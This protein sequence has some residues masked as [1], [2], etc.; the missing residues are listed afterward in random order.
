[1]SHLECRLNRRFWR[2]KKV[3]Q[4]V[5]IGGG[6]VIWAKS[7]RTPAFF[8]DVFPKPEAFVSYNQGV[9]KPSSASNST[10]MSEQ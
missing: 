7:K 6:G 3:L 1:M 9:I 2:S 5:Q 4:V 10:P 8:R